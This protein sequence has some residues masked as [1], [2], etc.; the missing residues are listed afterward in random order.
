MS[1]NQNDYWKEQ[2]RQVQKENDEMKK[3][4]EDLESESQLT[5]L[6][7]SMERRFIDELRQERAQK[8]EKVPNMA[9]FITK[10]DFERQKRRWNNE[11]KSFV[12]IITKLKN[13]I[14]VR[15][16]DVL[17]YFYFFIKVK[18]QQSIKTTVLIRFVIN[19][20]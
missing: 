19:Y 11:R 3:L 13:K 15:I 7:A 8:Q 17:I 20:F 9:L 6:V 1:T 2:H 14:Q 18:K 16:I 4:L 12:N 10:T 5:S